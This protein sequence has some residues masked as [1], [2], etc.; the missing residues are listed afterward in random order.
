MVSAES[1]RNLEIAEGLCNRG[2][3][4]EAV[5]Y[6]VKAMKDGNNLDAFVQTAFLCPTLAE[7]VE[8]LEA[9]IKKGTSQTL[10]IIDWIICDF[11]VMS[12]P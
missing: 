8:C 11:A 7:S 5:P 3:P 10:R 12:D 6:L 1:Q 4:N 2:K 9:G